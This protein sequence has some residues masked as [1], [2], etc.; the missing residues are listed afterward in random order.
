MAKQSFRGQLIQ[1]IVKHYY[2]KELPVISEKLQEELNK[3][4]AFETKISNVTSN[5]TMSHAKISFNDENEQSRVMDFI[6]E[7]NRLK[8]K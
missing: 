1:L 2:N 5:E 6:V 7:T 3:Y 8:F 4:L